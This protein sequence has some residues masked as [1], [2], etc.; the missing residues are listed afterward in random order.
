MLLDVRDNECEAARGGNPER[1]LTH[2]LDLSEGQAMANVRPK[3]TAGCSVA[4]CGGDY[5]ALGLCKFHY[6]RQYNGIPF[7]APRRRPNGQGKDYALVRIGGR[8]GR[9]VK[10]HRVVMEQILGRP[11]FPDEN[12]HHINGIRSDNR[13]ENLELWTTHQP[14]GQRVVDQVAWAKEIL[15]RYGEG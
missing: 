12:V 14:K 1:P 13:P 11:L 15:A 3:N 4:D 6:M 8:S 9:L 10:K 7:D 5:V 2:L